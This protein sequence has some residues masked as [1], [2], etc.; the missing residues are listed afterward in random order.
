MIN[1][2]EEA[3]QYLRSLDFICLPEKFTYFH[4][5]ACYIPPYDQQDGKNHKAWNNIPTEDF[6]VNWSL[7]CV[8]RDK[9]IE[10]AL[11]YG[12]LDKASISYAPEPGSK[13]FSI[14][15]IMP[16]NNLSA[17]EYQSLGMS[18]EEIK[19]LK[20][21]YA[22]LGDIRHTKLAN[23]EH[24]I[25]IGNITQDEVSGKD[26]DILYGVREQ[27]IIAYA[28]SVINELNFETALPNDKFN[29]F[30]S[31]GLTSPNP[32]VALQMYSSFDDEYSQ[33]KGRSR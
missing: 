19:K 26:I 20:F 5:N 13:L 33:E 23:K 2:I 31:Q 22:G 24:I 21:E 4:H 1:T 6:Y 8:E 10:E 15:I 28:N 30:K 11:S 27:D 32:E 16:K 14:R 25:M 3:I 9:R 12:G 18:G 7:S 29:R 17:E